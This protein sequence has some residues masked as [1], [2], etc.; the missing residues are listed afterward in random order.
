MCSFNHLKGQKG[1]SG[2]LNDL[3]NF[4]EEIK[5]FKEENQNEIRAIKQ[6]NNKELEDYRAQVNRELAAFLKEDWKEF[7]KNEAIAPPFKP[8]PLNL[9]KAL[10]PALPQPDIH[11][12]P[13]VNTDSIISSKKSISEG[14]TDKERQPLAT[15]L[16]HGIDTQNKNKENQHPFS[17]LDQSIQFDF[18]G[19]LLTVLYSQGMVIHCNSPTEKGVSEFWSAMAAQDYPVF[20]EQL[21]FIAGAYSLNDWGRYQLI[22]KISER[23]F[24]D[25]NDQRC[26]QFFYLNQMNFDARLA[27]SEEHLLLLLPFKEMVY[28][29]SYLN[30]GG[31]RFFIMDEAQ[32]AIYTFNKVLVKDESLFSLQMPEKL[33]LKPNISRKTYTLKNGKSLSIQY[34]LN[35]ILFYNDYPQADLSVF[36]N[37]QTSTQAETSLLEELR[38]LVKGINELDAVN[39]LLEFVYRNFPYKTDQDQFGKEKWFFLE[40]QVHY[41]YS[42][43]EDRSVFFSFL[44]KNLL[45][46]KVVGLNYPGHVAAAV[47]FNGYVNGDAILYKSERYIIADPTYIGAKAGMC[48]PHL[49]DISPKIVEMY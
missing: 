42:D 47:S 39:F 21:N 41:P 37:A 35:D 32:G 16:N 24:K 7:P 33:N 27:K 40:D 22:K 26:F 4:K 2:S 38:P 28:G 8:E 20:Q 25:K 14:N 11:S 18:Y 48:M 45:N 44:V 10:P 19:D 13:L 12:L 29:L 49:K 23:L 17:T 43:C 36:F 3:K 46:L 31:K 15:D 5:K 34:N 9:P 6:Q 1:D 30:L